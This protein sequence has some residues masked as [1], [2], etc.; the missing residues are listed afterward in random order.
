MVS[1]AWS[2]PDSV[3][4]LIHVS[5]VGE[6]LQ[7]L[8]K[9]KRTSS[10]CP[11]CDHSS[12][13]VHSRYTR[14]VQ[15]LPISGHP[16]DLLILTRKW[17]CD[18]QDCPVTIF[19]ER[20]EGISANRRRTVRTEQALQKIAFSTSCLAAEKVAHS[21]HIPVSHDALLSLIHRTEITPSVS[22]FSRH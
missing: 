10:T 13:R 1:F 6:T 2:P 9:S 19:T 18:Q 7:L 11:T 3:L 16:V 12:C 15:D 21:V 17:F 4:E 5:P 20:Y 22:P 8:I 14:K